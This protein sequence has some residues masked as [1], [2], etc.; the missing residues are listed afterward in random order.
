MLTAVERASVIKFRSEGVPAGH[1][2]LRSVEG[3]E[4]ISRPYRF[5]LT[6][7]SNS[8][9]VDAR[10]ILD[11]PASVQFKQGIALRG[12]MSRGRATLRLHGR[13]ASFEVRGREPHGV[14]YQATLVP[15]LQ[16]LAL[17]VRSRVFLKRSVPQIV[18]EVLEDNGLTKDDFSFHASA[19]AYRTREYVVQYNESD[20]DFVSRLL[21]QEG[22]FYFFRQEE[23]REKLV[24]ADHA[25]VHQPI[26]GL[27]V[28]PFIPGRAG[29][30]WFAQE[31]VRRMTGIHSRVPGEVV[32][33]DYNYRTPSVNLRVAAP[34]GAIGQGSVY[35]YG[36]HY[37]DPEEGLA[38]ARV[39]AEEIRCRERRFTGE[40]DV[41]S[42]RAGCTFSLDGHFRGDF[43][44]SYLVT[45]VRHVAEQ[46]VDS[47]GSSAAYRNEFVAIPADVPFRPPRVT[48]RPRVSTLN[49]R[50]G[51]SSDGKYAE[52][53]DRGRYKVTLP[54]DLSGREP[55][56]ASHWV[57]M[58]QP[59]GG[60]NYGVHFPLHKD[61]EVV[62]SHVN[63]DPDRPIIAA[64]V[65]NPEKPSIVKDAIQTQSVL[66]TGGNNEL[67]FEDFEG[68]EYVY[69]HAQRDME[70]RVTN[71]AREIIGGEQH[72]TVGGDRRD[73][74]GGSCH[75]TVGG[76]HVE[77]IGGAE[78]RTVAGARVEAI[79]G[80]SMRTVVKDS[81][82]DLRGAE[83]RHVVGESREGIDGAAHVSI[84]GDLRHKTGAA[85][86][87]TVT[88]DRKVRIGGSD[89]ATVTGK[90]LESIDGAL[91]RKVGA[92]QHE[93][94]G[95][96]L[97]RSVA[98]DEVVG[99]GGNLSL[100]VT[101]GIAQRCGQGWS[102]EV[103][104]DAYLKATNIVL[105]ATNA[106]TVKVGGNFITIDPTGV[107]I[108]GSLVKINSGGAAG[109]GSPGTILA[110]QTPEAPSAP[111]TP[112]A[113]STPE[114]PKKPEAPSEPLS[115]TTQP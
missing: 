23:D 109:S 49:A 110:P 2:R 103:S 30:Q 39:R 16:F 48:P 18:Q 54:L 99:I 70:T 51:A 45:E 40:S 9:D 72:V 75:E 73:R 24:V 87:V 17:T 105:E 86:H 104:G 32:L 14:V 47:H 68:S 91:H 55:H 28:V 84:G 83:H 34:T 44:A 15:R 101:G 59:Y 113:P 29:E 61:T 97:H 22:I 8:A 74:V 92:E 108:Q 66:K 60:T 4:A 106:I 62:L 33:K 26:L 96:A 57:R 63:G 77:D 115:G 31:S 36:E 65:P 82:E 50:V 52:V 6:L 1:L 88:G 25:A 102:S 94:I 80:V 79:G 71:R 5:A 85:L 11:H 111:E 90:R 10:S 43:N 112:Q 21:E 89:H 42:L 69:L 20:L 98:S 53:D 81:V 95:G 114:S 78:A 3:T 38:L 107:T 13:I 35:E 46:P 100:D 37:A 7:V 27:P 19:R 64:T 41:K 76:D 12:T 56:N 67:R 58:A 93:Q